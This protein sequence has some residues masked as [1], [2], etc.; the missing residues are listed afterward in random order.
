MSPNRL[1]SWSYADAQARLNELLE[2]AADGEPQR[3]T[4][5]D[6]SVI[7]ILATRTAQAQ[8]STTQTTPDS[9]S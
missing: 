1:P 6:G 3:I 9:P 8:V 4:Q 2:R 7:V 5:P